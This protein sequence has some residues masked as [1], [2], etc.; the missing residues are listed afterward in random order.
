MNEYNHHKILEITFSDENIN[1]SDLGEVDKSILKNVDINTLEDASDF[2]DDFYNILSTQFGSN[3]KESLKSIIMDTGYAFV[4][5]AVNGSPLGQKGALASGIISASQKFISNE[6]VSEVWREKKDENNYF[7]YHFF[8]DIKCENG[9]IKLY[10]HDEK[11]FNFI[12]QTMKKCC[13]NDKYKDRPKAFFTAINNREEYLI[14]GGA[15]GSNQSNSVAFLHAMGADCVDDRWEETEESSRKAFKDHLAKCFSEYLFLKN[16]KDALFMLGIA[17]HG[18]MDS[19]TPSHTGFQK[20]NSQDMAMHSQGDV[21]PIIITTKDKNNASKDENN[22]LIFDPGQYN[23]DSEIG[24]WKAEI[25]CGYNGDDFINDI[26]YKML[27]IFFYISDV[28]STFI[29]K[30]INNQNLYE[31]L[32]GKSKT[33]V[34]EVIHDSHYGDNANIFFECAKETMLAIYQSLKNGR[35]NVIKNNYSDYCIKQKKLVDNAIYIWEKAYNKMHTTHKE[36]INCLKN[37]FLKDGV[38]AGIISDCYSKCNNMKKEIKNNISETVD[39]K[40]GIAYNTLNYTMND[41]LESLAEQD[42]CHPF[43]GMNKM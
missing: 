18:I 38:N 2:T 43:G 33:K 12:E 35:E 17:L 41:T 23:D 10:R 13:I 11:N 28:E 37:M 32:K 19:F 16:E 31:S 39:Q 3:P 20:Y 5:G 25:K 9:I 29:E 42:L 36:K 26:E 6:D 40:K 1:K 22:K 30:K 21:I 8:Y 4:Q 7:Y 15:E 34:N 27:K 14:E 24:K